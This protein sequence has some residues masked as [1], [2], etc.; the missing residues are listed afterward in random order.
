MAKRFLVMAGTALL[1]SILLMLAVANLGLDGR[2][3]VARNFDIVVMIEGTD[4]VLACTMNVTGTELINGTYPP[5]EWAGSS[6]PNGNIQGWLRPGDYGVAL[7][8]TDGFYEAQAVPFKMSVNFWGRAQVQ[9][10]RGWVDARRLILELPPI[11]DDLPS[12]GGCECSEPRTPVPTPD[13]I[14][15]PTPVFLDEEPAPTE[16]PKFII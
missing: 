9:T 5:V 10:P 12:N 14:V 2:T 6:N 15:T 11:A 8:C 3:I 13:L 7:S 1:A 16:M 4:Q